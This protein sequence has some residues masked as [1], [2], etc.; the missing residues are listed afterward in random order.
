MSKNVLKVWRRLIESF[1]MKW[2]SNEIVQIY[3][4]HLD[5]Q[6]SCTLHIK[7]TRMPLSHCTAAAICAELTT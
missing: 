7:Q 6:C 3:Y 4:E 1:K 2:H 5:I